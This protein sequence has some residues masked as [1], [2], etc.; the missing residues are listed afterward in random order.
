M[1]GQSKSEWQ[2]EKILPTYSTDKG[3]TTLII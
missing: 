1:G 3:V 2:T